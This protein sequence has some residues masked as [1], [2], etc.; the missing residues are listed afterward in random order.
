MVNAANT[1]FSNAAVCCG[2]RTILTRRLEELIRWVAIGA[3]GRRNDHQLVGTDTAPHGDF[4]P[5]QMSGG[6]E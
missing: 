5:D 4:D 1:T 6:T 3:A 2:S